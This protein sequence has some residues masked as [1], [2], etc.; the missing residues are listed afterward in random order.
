M[1]FL[2]R[3]EDRPDGSEKR[4]LTAA[5]IRSGINGTLDRFRLDMSR[6]PTT[7]EGLAVLVNSSSTDT[8]AKKWAGPYVKKLTDM[9]DAWGHNL[10][11]QCPGQ[12]NVDS[13][14]LAS[15]GP[16]GQLGTEDDITNWDL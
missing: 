8:D 1:I 7:A 14:D 16:D 9:K 10:I 2:P 13:Y 12:H 5:L 6:Y 3:I 4:K 11:Y 15:P